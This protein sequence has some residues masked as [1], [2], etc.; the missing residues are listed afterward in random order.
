MA[1]NNGR[2]LLKRIR[3]H[4]AELRPAERRLADL[5][6]NFPGE[7][8]G[9]SATELA[10][11]AETSNAA[12]S[13]FVQRIGLRTYDEMRRLSREGIDGGSPHFFLHP[14]DARGD[15]SAAA[16]Y[17]DA[18]I[19]ALRRTFAAIGERDIDSLAAA[20]RTAPDVWIVGYRHAHFLAA[21]LHWQVCHVRPRVHLLPRAG[22]TYGEVLADAGEGDVVIAVALRR[23]ARA[24][25][26]VL[27]ALRAAGARLALVGDLSLTDDYGAEWVF[28]CDTR[29]ATAVDNHAA[30]LAAIQLILDRIIVRA[31]KDA[32]A[33]FAGIDQLHE[34]LGE[35]GG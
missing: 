15:G 13:R 3:D 32:A 6:L 31:G 4:Y 11:M 19:E 12:V 23:R 34:D 22:S 35:L 18:T 28:R 26:D 7:I 17:R 33:R 27:A 2:S 5:I 25:G 21:W 8:A 24:L 20:V 29:T 9:Y 1:P 10:G 16:F 14:G 30:V